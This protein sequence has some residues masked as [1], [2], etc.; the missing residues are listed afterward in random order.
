MA[1]V[2]GRPPTAFERHVYEACSAVPAGRVTTYGIMAA[3]VGSSAR[4]VGQALRRNPFAPHVPCHR[5]IAAGGRLGGFSGSAGGDTPQL[6]HKVALL[7]SEGV[8]FLGLG[9]GGGGGGV[10]ATPG[11][12][13]GP[14]ELA[15]ALAAARAQAGKQQGQ[16]Q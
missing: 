12:V 2:V 4:A 13:M 3:V 6:R 14:D 11:A 8:A 10:C 1:P 16:A 5:I 7:K 15:A 9:G